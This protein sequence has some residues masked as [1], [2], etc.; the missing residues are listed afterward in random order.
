MF[1]KLHRERYQSHQFEEEALIQS[2]ISH[3]Q[4][5]R[6]ENLGL[7]GDFPACVY[8]PGEGSMEAG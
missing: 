3:I 8:F 5:S 7:L 2:E 4:F 1:W 6:E